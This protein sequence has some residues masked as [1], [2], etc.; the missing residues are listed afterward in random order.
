MSDFTYS[1]YVNRTAIE[2]KAL[3]QALTSLH[4][5][6]WLVACCPKWED[7]LKIAHK[8]HR[9]NILMGMPSSGAELILLA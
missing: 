1:S 6:A 5:V 9:N 2:R 8:S 3:H 4:Q 7:Q